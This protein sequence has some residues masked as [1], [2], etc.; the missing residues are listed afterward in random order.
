MAKSKL[1]SQ[2]TLFVHEYLVDLNAGEAALRA[3]YKNKSR[4]AKL[5]RRA[6]V[7]E[8]IAKEMKK[9]LRRIDVKAD[10][11]LREIGVIAF[12]DIADYCDV[13]DGVILL[14]NLSDIPKALRGAIQEVSETVTTKSNVIRVKLHPKVPVLK[15]AAEHVGLVGAGVKS[16]TEEGFTQHI[17]HVTV[18][19]RVPGQ[20]H[21]LSV[22]EW[23][24]QIR[25][26]R[27][28]REAERATDT[29]APDS[30]GPS[31]MP[32]PRPGSGTPTSHSAG[33]A[34]GSSSV[35]ESGSGT[36]SPNPTTQAQE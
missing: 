25:E 21:G 1:S 4:G 11:V 28:K 17:H 15:L 22:E 10:R 27:A 3:K 32:E 30:P 24:R 26:A 18:A 6:S 12:S 8:A 7:Q 13:R 19:D 14:K 23:E 36:P 34:G 5:L 31:P 16:D 20:E 29:P 9:R 2:E 33:T 35:S